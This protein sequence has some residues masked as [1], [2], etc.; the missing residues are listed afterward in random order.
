MYQIIK[1]ICNSLISVILIVMLV[2]AGILL[3]P[4]L[5][6]YQAY[7]VL[8]GS[9]EPQYSVGSLVFVKPVPPE[10]IQVQDSITFYLSGQGGT[11]ATHR[12]IAIDEQNQTFTTKGDANQVADQPVHFDKLVGRVSE[13]SVPYYGHL[14]TM[15]RTTRGMLTG[16]CVILFVVLLSFLPDIFKPSQ[17]SEEKAVKT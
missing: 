11:V 10:Q 3:G 14:V 15:L 2:S 17:Q 12:V 13:H 9:M 1:T 7:S 5:F 6:G 4:H 8:S 16:A